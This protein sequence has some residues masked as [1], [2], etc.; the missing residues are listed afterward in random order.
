VATNDRVTIHLTGD[1]AESYRQRAESQDRSLSAEVRQALRRDL[2]RQN[3][4]GQ[5]DIGERS[6]TPVEPDQP[7]TRTWVGP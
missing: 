3:G 5:S 6:A 1:L 2:Q 4:E 7:P